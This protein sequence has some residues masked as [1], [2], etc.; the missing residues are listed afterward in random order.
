MDVKQ[1][2]GCI[3]EHFLLQ[4]GMFQLHRIVMQSVPCRVEVNSSFL[5]SFFS[6]KCLLPVLLNIT[7][8]VGI[9]NIQQFM[10]NLYLLNILLKVYRI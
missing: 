5:L 1:T 8:M 4:F 2:I 7:V 9:F 6:V 10:F 3:E